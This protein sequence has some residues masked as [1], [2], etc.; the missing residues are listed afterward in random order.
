[1]RITDDLVYDVGMHNGDDAEYYL[2]KGFRVIGIDANPQ[3]CAACAVRFEQE[4]AQGRL[5]VLNLGVGPEPGRATFYVNLRESQISSFTIPTH[6]LDPWD[7]IQV[8]IVP[9][10]DLM[11]QY[12]IPHFAKIDVE[13][14]D[15]LVLRD[16]LK[17]DIR[18]AYISAES[19][20]IDTFVALQEMGYTEYKLVEGVSVPDVYGHHQITLRN[21]ER[22]PYAF[23]ALSSGPFG[24]DV[25]GRWLTA[26]E[27]SERLKT[28][29][30]GWVDIHARL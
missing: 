1:M 2:A 26:D 5:V 30:L 29:G 19:H 12:G 16:L 24:E 25:N 6:S 18:P 7:K 23:Q 21:G 8:D 17:R 11:R 13:H 22:A 3:L 20:T 4:M 28:V 9:L 15:H 14:Y 10:S 27:L